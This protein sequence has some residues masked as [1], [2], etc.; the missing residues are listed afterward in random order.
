MR[1]QTKHVRPMRR[2]FARLLSQKALPATVKRPCND[3]IVCATR[4]LI[5]LSALAGR[6]RVQARIF[7][8]LII[9][10][11]YRLQTQS[12]LLA[13]V[14]PPACKSRTQ[15]PTDLVRCTTI[16]RILAWLARISPRRHVHVDRGKAGLPKDRADPSIALRGRDPAWIRSCT[17][18]AGGSDR[19]DDLT[20][21]IIRQSSRR[22]GHTAAQ[23]LRP[24][25]STISG[26]F[27]NRT[28]KRSDGSTGY[29]AQPHIK[30]AGKIVHREDRTLERNHFCAPRN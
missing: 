7:V 14:S 26:A 4:I 6:I 30:R 11:F 17:V 13:S 16:Y 5:S 29:Q 28:R 12:T 3:P 15:V 20:P 8:H 21:P 24:S 25:G 19:R 23:Y 10:Y 22:L 18:I 2:H 27:H 9:I 1:R